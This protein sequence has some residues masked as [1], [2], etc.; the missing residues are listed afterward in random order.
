M[1]LTR[2]CCGELEARFE[3]EVSDLELVSSTTRSYN[4]SSYCV[5]L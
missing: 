3:S 1:E 2:W 5:I 4:K